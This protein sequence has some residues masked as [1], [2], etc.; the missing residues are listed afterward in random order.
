M[1]EIKQLRKSSLIK[2]QTKSAEILTMIKG[3]TNYHD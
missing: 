1:K 2:V 3:L